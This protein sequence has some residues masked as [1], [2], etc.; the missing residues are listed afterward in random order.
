MNLKKT[1]AALS[2]GVVAVASMATVAAS[3]QE[4]GSRTF[5]TYD[6]K[7]QTVATF[8]VTA[9]MANP[10]DDVD[11]D[12][13]ALEAKDTFDGVEWDWKDGVKV[14]KL[15]R[16]S[17]TYTDADEIDVFS[18]YAY[19]PAA[20]QNPATMELTLSKLGLEAGK[21]VVVATVEV[22]TKKGT[23]KD[24]VKKLAKA[25]NDEQVIADAA[26]TGAA[27]AKVTKVSAKAVSDKFYMQIASNLKKEKDTTPTVNTDDKYNVG[28]EQ[29]AEIGGM[30]ESW[31][32]TT[33]AVLGGLD[34][35]IANTLAS[36]RGAK[37]VFYFQ[38]KMD[39]EDD[40]LDAAP[41]YGQDT[42]WSDGKT[43]DFA[44]RVNGTK[45]LKGVGVVDADALTI[46]FDWDTVL[47]ESNLVNAVGQVDTI[48]YKANEDG[49]LYNEDYDNDKDDATYR[50][51]ITK[52]VVEWPASDAVAEDM[53]DL[54]AG[55]A[56]TTVE[57]ALP[58][59][60]AAATT[61]AA[62]TDAAANPSTG[63]SAV[64]LAVIPVAI[65]AAAFVAKKRG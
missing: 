29:W 39:A 56:E 2:A 18:D 26:V 61:V 28:D 52:I 47:S 55:E 60:D 12:L 58:G 9:A 25:C 48:E 23:D 34:T 8:T 19:T 3:A 54:A 62:A 45:S 7:Y 53:S 21:S 57:A 11:I 63:N 65:A 51:E 24:A 38:D 35:E 20:N 13:S 1:L 33:T 37:L 6:V 44:I 5:D 40:G 22:K 31:D 64:A 10:L 17:D 41:D 30:A 32:P 36:N 46:S 50:Y 27:D 59:A 43:E 42:G 49:F 16:G 4:A 15:K 14:T